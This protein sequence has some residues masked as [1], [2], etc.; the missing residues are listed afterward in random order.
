MKMRAVVLLAVFA[1]FVVFCAAD[2]QKC[3]LD[4][5]M[6]SLTKSVASAVLEK[7]TL[8]CIDASA[9]GSLVDCPAGYKPTGCSCGNACG[10]WDIRN[11]QTCHCQCANQDWTAARCCKIALK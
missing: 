8:S 4:G 7:V 1:V 11:D 5:L 10:S 9:R 2:N 6:S 3:A